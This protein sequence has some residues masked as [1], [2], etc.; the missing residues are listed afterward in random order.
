MTDKLTEIKGVT[1]FLPVD[2]KQNYEIAP[3]LHGEETVYLLRRWLDKYVP[4]PKLRGQLNKFIEQGS[5]SKLRVLVRLG[6]WS[7][8]ILSLAMI[9][10]FAPLITTF[11]LS[12]VVLPIQ[13]MMWVSM[14]YKV[15]IFSG[16]KLAL[17]LI[18]EIQ[19]S[20]KRSI[21]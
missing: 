7:L 11:I 13:L 17:G 1:F 19:S 6:Q 4:E 14:I 5:I 16:G 8:P 21:D 20:E 9:A 12:V 3:Q 15:L 10:A 18:E 2:V